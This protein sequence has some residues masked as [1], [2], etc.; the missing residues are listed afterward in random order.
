M[1]ARTRLFLAEFLLILLFTVVHVY[2]AC[3]GGVHVLPH[4][5]REQLQG[6]LSLLLGSRIL[7][8]RKLRRDNGQFAAQASLGLGNP[9]A[10][11]STVGMIPG[12]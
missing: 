9:P 1:Q 4:T 10:S 6:A 12:L 8:P 11:A 5:C 7:A 2:I 3:V